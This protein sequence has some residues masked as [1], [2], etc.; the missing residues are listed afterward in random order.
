MAP[1]FLGGISYSYNDKNGPN[2]AKTLFG[3]QVCFLF[4]LLMKILDL[5]NNL[6]HQLNGVEGN[7]NDSDNDKSPTNC[8]A[9]GGGGGSK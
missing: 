5:I 9:G 8:R 2:D 1:P 4:T 7:H 6:Q 3:P